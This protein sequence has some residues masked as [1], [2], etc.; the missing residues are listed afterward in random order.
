MVC[1]KKDAF[2]KLGISARLKIAVAV[3]M[4]AT[5][6][7]ADGMD[8]D[9]WMSQTT[10]GEALRR[11][12]KAV[13]CLY[14]KNALWNPTAADLRKI[15]TVANKHGWPGCAGSIDCMHI[16]WKNCPSA[17]KGMF[18]GMKGDGQ[19]TIVIKAIADHNCCFWHF[20]AGMPGSLNDLNVLLRSTLLNNALAGCTPSTLFMVNY[21]TYNTVYWLSDGIYPEH[22]CFVKT[23]PKPSMPQ[24]KLFTSRHEAKRKEVKRAFGIMQSWWHTITQ[25]CK[26]WSCDD[27]QNVLTT[28]VIFHNMIID[29]QLERGQSIYTN[30]V[31]FPAKDLL[32]VVE[33]IPLV[34]PTTNKVIEELARIQS[35]A[36]HFCLKT[37]LIHH[38]WNQFGNNQL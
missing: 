35:R 30:N 38:I 27:I 7:S 14:K 20:M 18:C 11:L 17:W 8:D 4:L 12:C 2:G 28:V 26:L 13:I 34:P 3:R 1:S 37:D 19:A 23:Y 5:G 10:C 15:L 24:Q 25:P 36:M 32:T 6:N 29:H 22:A 31:V 9:Y 33:R 21:S 16:P